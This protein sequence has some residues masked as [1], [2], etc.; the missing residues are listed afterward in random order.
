MRLLLHSVTRL[1]AVDYVIFLV[2]KLTSGAT[3]V[4]L[5]TDRRQRDK[6]I[7]SSVCVAFRRNYFLPSLFIYIYIFGTVCYDLVYLFIYSFIHS[8]GSLS[9]TTRL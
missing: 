2:W 3:T 6:L 7:C 8:F 5:I 9:L 1:V 4:T